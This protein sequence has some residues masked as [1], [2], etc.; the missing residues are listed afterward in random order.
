MNTIRLTI[1]SF[2]FCQSM[3]LGVKPASETTFKPF[4]QQVADEAIRAKKQEAMNQLQKQESLWGPTSKKN[5]ESFMSSRER[6][7]IAQIKK[8]REAQIKKDKEREDKE[9]EDKERKDKIKKEAQMQKNIN[10]PTR[11]R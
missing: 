11:R 9:R 3:F 6:E 1:I 4:N 5:N 2:L 7:I 10:A 8:E